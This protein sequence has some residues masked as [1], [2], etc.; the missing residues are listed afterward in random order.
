MTDLTKLINFQKKKR[1]FLIQQFI[2]LRQPCEIFMVQN[3][4]LV[5]VENEGILVINLTYVVGPDTSF[6]FP[7]SY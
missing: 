2:H 4:L 1:T 5:L 6:R 7:C 3:F